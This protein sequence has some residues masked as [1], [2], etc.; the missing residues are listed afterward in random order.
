[1]VTRRTPRKN[2]GTKMLEAPLQAKLDWRPWPRN[3]TL[4]VITK[5]KYK[6]TKK[7]RVQGRESHCSRWPLGW[8]LEYNRIKYEYRESNRIELLNVSR[9]ENNIYFSELKEL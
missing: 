6:E 9:E 8:H 1:M 3:E 5:S 7:G 2:T 4:K